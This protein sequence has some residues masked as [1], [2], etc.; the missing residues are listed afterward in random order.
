M[1][2][3]L[4]ESPSD[5]PIETFFS[6]S[7]YWRRLSRKTPLCAEEESS[8]HSPPGDTHAAEP[9]SIVIPLDTPAECT[10][11]FDPHGKRDAKNGRLPLREPQEEGIDH[12]WVHERSN[13]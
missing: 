9:G 10:L 12:E 7:P 6:R 8:R 3:G 4:D 13:R 11:I 1:G 5:Q 2:A